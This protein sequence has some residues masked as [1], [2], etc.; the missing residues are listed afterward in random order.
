MSVFLFFAQIPQ[1]EPDVCG[2]LFFP[3]VEDDKDMSV[4]FSSASNQQYSDQCLLCYFLS[5]I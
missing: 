3:K 2:A 1:E 4:F 5:K